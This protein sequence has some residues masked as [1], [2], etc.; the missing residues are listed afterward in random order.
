MKSIS[1][2]RIITLILKSG[3]KIKYEVKEN[4][5]MFEVLREINRDGEYD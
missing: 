3:K 2:T 1:K 5:K 4:K